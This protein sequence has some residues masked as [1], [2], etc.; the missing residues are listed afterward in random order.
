TPG[1]AAQV[2]S[3]KLSAYTQHSDDHQHPLN[4]H[5]RSNNGTG[6]STQR[7]KTVPS[8]WKKRMADRLHLNEKSLPSV[9]MQLQ[10]QRLV[11][12]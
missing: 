8:R 5:P 2:Q 12:K 10:K 1:S 9:F 3:N 6:G 4:F 11:H 7:P